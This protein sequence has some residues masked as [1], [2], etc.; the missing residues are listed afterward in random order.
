MLN[1]VSDAFEME[2]SEDRIFSNV[3][4]VQGFHEDGRCFAAVFIGPEAERRARDYDAAVSTG[5][6]PLT[7][8]NNRG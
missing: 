6:L 2:I 3:W 1:T 4:R 5:M 7:S 8:L